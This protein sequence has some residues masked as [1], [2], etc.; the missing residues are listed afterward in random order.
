MH[1]LIKNS[2]D[3]ETKKLNKHTHTHIHTHTHTYTNQYKLTNDLSLLNK[4]MTGKQNL[5]MS[6]S[7]TDISEI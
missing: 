1:I 5:N 6:F 3:K 2:R 7:N 4:D